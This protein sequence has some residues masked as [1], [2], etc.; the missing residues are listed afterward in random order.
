MDINDKAKAI[1]NLVTAFR[2]LGDEERIDSILV[3]AKGGG[4][5][6]PEPEKRRSGVKR[7]P[8]KVSGIYKAVAEG[9]APL[10]TLVTRAE[11][12]QYVPGKSMEEKI[13]WLRLAL[14]KSKDTYRDYGDG[15]W[16]LRRQKG[17]NGD[18][19]TP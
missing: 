2:D 10:D 18:Q 7:G 4:Q 19:P 5:P 15:S 6:A 16:G 17:Q 9:V 13:E 8:Y 3:A 1:E 11:K 14:K 12:Y